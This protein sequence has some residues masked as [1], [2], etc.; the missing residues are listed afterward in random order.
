M[1]H[2]VITIR[3]MNSIFFRYT[4][5]ND[6]HLWLWWSWFSREFL[7]L[8]CMWLT[9]VPGRWQQS[10]PH[11]LGERPDRSRKLHVSSS[12]PART[13]EIH[14]VTNMKN[15][16][17]YFSIAMIIARF[18]VFVFW[19]CY[20]FISLCDYLSITVLLHKRVHNK[21]FWKPLHHTCHVIF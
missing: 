19:K 18:K 14:E 4:I 13:H 12:G 21:I 1:S 11:G 20:F 17:R 15:I 2:K 6:K 3:V 9:W 8:F 10:A 5:W 7:F 16:S